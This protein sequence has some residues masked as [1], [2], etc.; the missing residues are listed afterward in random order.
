MRQCCPK[1]LSGFLPA[2]RPIGGECFGIP[3]AQGDLGRCER[4][5]SPHD[6]EHN[7]RTGLSQ[8]DQAIDFPH[9][10]RAPRCGN[11]GFRNQRAGAVFLVR[12]LQARREIYSITH[13]GVTHHEMRADAPGEHVP[14]GNA[15]PDVAFHGD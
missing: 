2:L 7:V 3:I 9:F 4:S 15:E 1:R 13:H 6:L 5:R 10:N 14:S 11:R 8:H 12:R